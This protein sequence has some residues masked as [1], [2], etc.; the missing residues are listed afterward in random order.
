MMK[1]RLNHLVQLRE[2]VA[3]ERRTPDDIVSDML[4][5]LASSIVITRNY[6]CLDG[7][8]GDVQD[9]LGGNL[10]MP[11]AGRH[12]GGGP[13]NELV[14]A[15]RSPLRALSPATTS[16]CS[17]QA[18][19]HPLGIVRTDHKETGRTAPGRSP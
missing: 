14:P 11:I 10:R 4:A 6:G 3:N 1:R 18:G 13:T 17:V 16:A 8:S 5:D 2:V 15:L 7:R 12:A 19:G 9:H